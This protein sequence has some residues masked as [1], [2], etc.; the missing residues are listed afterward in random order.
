MCDI[1]SVRENKKIKKKIEKKKQFFSICF[2][3]R[4][5]NLIARFALRD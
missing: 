5:D 2:T 3:I 4:A 1:S